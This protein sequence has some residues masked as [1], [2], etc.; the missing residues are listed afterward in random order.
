MID[1][2]VL[3]HG[4]VGSPVRWSDGCQKACEAAFAQLEAGGR[5]LDAVC[6][7]AR[8]L[9]DDGRFNAGLGSTLRLDGKTIEMDASLMDSKGS[10][11][12]VIS[13]KNVQNPILVARAVLETPHVAL[14]GY[15]AE[16]FAR[17]RG[18][19][20]F[21]R[22]SK[23]SKARY[24]DLLRMIRRGDLGKH[25]PRWEECD[26]R[27]LWN[28]DT[29]YETTIGVDTI[30]VVALDR[31]GNFAVANSTGGASPMLLGRV[32]DTPM[33]GCGYYAGPFAAIACTG[34]GEDIIR[35]MLARKVYEAVAD[36]E[37][38]RDAARESLT[39]FPGKIPV[40][41]IAITR[42]GCTI[43][44]NRPMAHYALVQQK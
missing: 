20:P 42:R 2:G 37:D 28:F 25:D 11:G 5:A 8:I 33:P 40:G 29:P 22:P 24:K 41:V 13:I 18:L 30:G 19:E 4:G 39:Q 23:Q 31:N 6:E 43:T 38:V 9:E 35:R 36:K 1:Y 17:K 32:G 27:S 26:I 21:G 7:A 34:I 3:V 15:G 44:S 10:L 14:S 16:L 12:I